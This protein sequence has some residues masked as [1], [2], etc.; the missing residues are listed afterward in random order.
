MNNLWLN[1]LLGN[2]LLE[3]IALEYIAQNIFELCSFGSHYLFYMCPGP[4]EEEKEEQ[5]QVKESKEG[6]Q[7]TEGE[8]SRARS[9][10]G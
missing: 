8:A 1:S 4:K 9:E 2:L 6:D 3:E 5:I 10:E 7:T